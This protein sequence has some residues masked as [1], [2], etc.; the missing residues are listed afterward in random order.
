MILAARSLSSQLIACWR[1]LV[2]VRLTHAA[3]SLSPARLP[4]QPARGAPSGSRRYGSPAAGCPAP[5]QRRPLVVSGVSRF[6]APAAWRCWRRLRRGSPDHGS[7]PTCAWPGPWRTEIAM[8]QA[9]SPPLG[10]LP[11][12][13]SGQR[14][15]NHRM[16]SGGPMLRELGDGPGLVAGEQMSR[17]ATARAGEAMAMR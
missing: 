5:G 1:R 4:P 14:D 13:R 2:M 8:E 7:T 10:S 16:S 17:R 9:F 11:P 15:R 12:P 6:A 3:V